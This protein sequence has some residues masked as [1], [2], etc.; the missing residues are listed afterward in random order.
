MYNFFWY[1]NTLFLS[2]W[3]RAIPISFCPTP[4]KRW[5]MGVIILIDK[6]IVPLIFY[7]ND[8]NLFFWNSVLKFFYRVG[9]SLTGVQNWTILKK[10]PLFLLDFLWISL[11]VFF[12]Q[13]SDTCI[14]YCFWVIWGWRGNTKNIDICIFGPI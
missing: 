10:N 8:V 13:I 6:A 14:S 12:N 1:F 2:M 3:Q 5:K 11:P 7:D 9:L 4:F